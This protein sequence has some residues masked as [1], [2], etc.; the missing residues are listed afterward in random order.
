[1]RYPDHYALLHTTL[2]TGQH[3]GHIPPQAGDQVSAKVST[4]S[5]SDSQTDLTENTSSGED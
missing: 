2:A 4:T 5:P 1:M 3:I